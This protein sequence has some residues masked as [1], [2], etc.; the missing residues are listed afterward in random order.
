MPVRSG[1][2]NWLPLDTWSSMTESSGTD[3]PA[4]GLVPITSPAGRGCPPDRLDDLGEAVDGEVL[5]RDVDGLARHVGDRL[6]LGS[7]RRR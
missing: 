1:I 6:G 4:G 7:R 2:T 5:L 3:S